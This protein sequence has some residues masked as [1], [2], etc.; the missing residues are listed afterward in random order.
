MTDYSE[1]AGDHNFV[2]NVAAR[3]E[4]S[5]KPHS[6]NRHRQ[7][8]YVSGIGIIDVPTEQ[9][10]LKLMEDILSSKA[11]EQSAFKLSALTVRH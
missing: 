11:I 10:I 3:T 9:N 7:K 6:S 2:R 5:C 1:Y 4:N 8:Q